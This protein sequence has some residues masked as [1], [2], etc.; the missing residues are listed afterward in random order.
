MD[1][2]EEA[3]DPQDESPTSPRDHD[4]PTEDAGAAARPD[5][6]AGASPR[7]DEPLDEL[8]V[9]VAEIATLQDKLKRAEAG[10][11]N[12][13]K[14]IR[15][16]ADEDRKYAIERVVV[17]LLPVV[18]A[19]DAA[20]AALGDDDAAQAMREGLNLVEKQLQGVF[21]RYGIAA[22]E[23]LGRPFDP[24][25]HQAMMMVEHAELA[26]Q[27]VSHVMRQGYELN[28]RVIRPAEVAVVKPA[29]E[30]PAEAPDSA[31]GEG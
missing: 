9:R 12:E 17:D 30:E 29:V 27:T 18:D 4:A 20:R 28:G 2:V 10:F 6:G 7:E 16:K 5:E 13:A 11:V 8:S 26:P 1:Q 31:E 14:R 25:R 3:K 15:R 19:L 24:A 21:E 23:A 22:I